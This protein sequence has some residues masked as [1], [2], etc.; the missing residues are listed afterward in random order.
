MPQLTRNMAGFSLI[1]ILVTVAITIIGL[2][3]LASLQL[4]V[5]KSVGDSGNRSQVIW[6]LEDL[7]NRMKANRIA[8]ADYNTD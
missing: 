8:F 7:S 3:G 4:Q 5:T 6:M 2:V 1:E